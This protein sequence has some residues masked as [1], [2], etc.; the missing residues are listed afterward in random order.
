[1]TEGIAFKARTAKTNEKFIEKNMSGV[2][3]GD[4][5]WFHGRFN[6]VTKVKRFF[7][8]PNAFMRFWTDGSGEHPI[9]VPDGWRVRVKVF[10]DAEQ[11]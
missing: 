3:V 5:I 2:K 8:P 10:D 11:I 4:W 7:I 6:K 1:M 9:V